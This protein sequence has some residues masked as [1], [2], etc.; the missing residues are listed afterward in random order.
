MWNELGI[1]KE[2]VMGYL[3]N[4]LRSRRDIMEMN[5]LNSLIIAVDFDGTLSLGEWPSCGPANTELMNY[6]K[7][8]KALG[9]RLIL[10]TCRAGEQL[11]DAVDWCKSYGMEFDAIND[12]LPEIVER[13]G[14]NSRKIC[15]DYY[16]DDKAVFRDEYRVVDGEVF[17]AV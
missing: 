11:Q 8:R 16:I 17:C 5:K 14:G 7:G 6:L 9:D 3:K 4:K 10:W 13:Y 2:L 15:C 1:L 12:N